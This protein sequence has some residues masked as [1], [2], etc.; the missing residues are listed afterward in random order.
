MINGKSCTI[1]RAI[2]GSTVFSA[3]REVRGRSWIQKWEVLIEKF[4]LYYIVAD[5]T[6]VNILISK[7]SIIKC[8]T[9]CST[10][11][12]TRCWEY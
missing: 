6:Q 11:M 5:N 4:D 1:S 10:L 2:A 9:K 7:T 3:K 12:S 8:I